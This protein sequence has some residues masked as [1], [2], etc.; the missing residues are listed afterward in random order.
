M[1]N[2]PALSGALNPDLAFV[3]FDYFFYDCESQA[4]TFNLI[5]RASPPKQFEH[6]AAVFSLDSD[7]VISYRKMME[8][9]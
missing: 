6:L 5:R 9:I 7:P 3:Q 8:I 2:C 1:K 4:C